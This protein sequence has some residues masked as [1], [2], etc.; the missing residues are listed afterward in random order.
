[1]WY[2]ERKKPGKELFTLL[3]KETREQLGLS[4]PDNATKLNFGK[5]GESSILTSKMILNYM[6]ENKELVDAFHIPFCRHFVE[7][8]GDNEILTASSIYMWASRHAGNCLVHRLLLSFEQSEGPDSDFDEPSQVTSIGE[9]NE[10]K[11]VYDQ[12]EDEKDFF[13]SSSM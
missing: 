4:R 2:S 1:M 12:S 5:V 11:D 6:F 10:Q 7:N 3:D 13:F 8:A 9:K